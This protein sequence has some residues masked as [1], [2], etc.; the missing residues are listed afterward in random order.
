VG[1]EDDR[2]P[3]GTQGAEHLLT[4]RRVEVVRRLVEQ[5]HVRARH[6][7]A[8]QRQPRLLTAGQS[9]RRLQHGVAAEQE[10]AED[11]ALLDL[12]QVR[13]DGGEVREHGGIGVQ[14][15]VLLRVVAELQP[16]AGKHLT[17]VR[18]LDP[19]EHAQQGGLARAVETE[20]DHAAGAVDREVD[21]DEHL[22]RA[23]ALRQAARRERDAPARRRVGEAD[24]RDTVGAT[25]GLDTGEQSL[26]TARHVL[27][28][29]RLGRLRAHLV[30]L[31]HQRGRLLLRV[32]PLA[33]AASLVDL[34]LLQVGL[35][36]D[37]V[38]VEGG[39][40]GVEMEHL[41]H[42][43][44]EQIDVVADDDEPAGIG[45]QVVAQ[46]A[47]GIGVE[48]VGRLVEQQRL[49]VGEQDPGE[50]HAP[51]L[52]AGQRAQRLVEHPRRQ[53]EVGA[54]AL[55]VRLRA[56]ATEGGELL[57]EPA[58]AAEERSVLRPLTQLDLCFLHRVQQLVD[59][60]RGQ[61]PIPGDRV[62][63]TGARVL[64]Q[65][66]DGRGALDR[67]GGRDA[68]AGQDLAQCGLTGPVTPDEADPVTRG[69]PERDGLE[70]Q[71]RAGAQL[72]TGDGQHD[73]KR[74]PGC[75]RRADQL[76]KVTPSSVRR[77]CAR[78]P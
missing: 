25:L 65:V 48:V 70:Q 69:D 59:A 52:P 33:V 36:P 64:R 58:V 16:V 44:V 5:Q 9:A 75:R 17:G 24:A 76:A 54:D 71:P 3:V 45:A 23:V 4:A 11:F 1:D 61:H 35:P 78:R 12:G 46:P 2:A 62:E 38:E 20:D 55:R 68:L 43:R 29:D 67:A 31:L 66:P 77:P 6:D 57:F 26:C 39:A 21:V 32:G 8:G 73:E 41:V 56:V 50:L 51:P 34:T 63:V 72:Q 10:R 14:S 74:L 42:H 53:A 40:V 7:E 27:R 47:D 18:V 15:L 28:G 22:E 60:T 13:C 37:V 49:R 30:G 19:R